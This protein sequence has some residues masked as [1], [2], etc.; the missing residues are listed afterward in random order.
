[1]KTAETKAEEGDLS[2]YQ[3]RIVKVIFSGLSKSFDLGV[4]VHKV[5][6]KGELKCVN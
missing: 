2:D 3:R 6:S 4:K 1:M 5:F